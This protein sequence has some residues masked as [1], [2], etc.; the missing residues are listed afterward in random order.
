MATARGVPRHTLTQLIFTRCPTHDGRPRSSALLHDNNPAPCL[1]RRD[2]ALPS[3]RYQSVVR[4]TNGARSVSRR[5]LVD[6]ALPRHQHHRRSISRDTI[7]SSRYF[8]A[9]LFLLSPK[10]VTF[11]HS[12]YTYVYSL[13]PAN[14]RN[15]CESKYLLFFGKDI[16]LFNFV[17]ALFLGTMAHWGPPHLIQN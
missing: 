9:P 4:L 8:L 13:I 11:N 14:G 5:S 17:L 15:F 3:L 10:S 1:F 2:A 6:G 12:K 16:V 7:D